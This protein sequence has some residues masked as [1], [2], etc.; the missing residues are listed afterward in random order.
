MTT[1]LP[2][3][4]LKS[5]VAK[6]VRKGVTLVTLVAVA[7]LFALVTLVATRTCV[8]LEASRLTW[9]PG[10][11]PDPVPLPV[12]RA[13]GVADVTAVN[14]AASR[15]GGT[16]VNSTTRVTGGRVCTCLSCA[17]ANGVAGVTKIR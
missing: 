12:R 6:R 16:T 14:G 3:F 9:E 5:E 11:A 10:N 1:R 17:N 13:N 2:D 7:V 8:P 4:L 15:N